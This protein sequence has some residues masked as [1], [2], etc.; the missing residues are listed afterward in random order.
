MKEVVTDQLPLLDTG[1]RAIIRRNAYANGVPALL[2]VLEGTEEPW[3]VFTLN[4][5]EYA[6]RLGKNQ[7]F[8]K[9]YSEGEG[10]LEALR[11][12]GVIGR[13]LFEVKTGYVTVPAVEVLLEASK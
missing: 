4:L 11:K 5:P 9:T 10:N 13:T 2:A 6:H 8:L 12:L 1:Q 3:A 7:A